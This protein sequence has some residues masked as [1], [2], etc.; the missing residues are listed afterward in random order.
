[1]PRA[2]S[3][4]VTTGA[5]ARGQGGSPRQGEVLTSAPMAENLKT[6]YGYRINAPGFLSL[7][8][9][10]EW[11]EDLK[12]LIGTSGQPFGLLVDIRSQRANPPESQAVI[13]EAMAWV[14]K[15]GLVR[16]AVVLDSA[17]AKLQT[18]RLAKTSGVYAWERYIDASKDL[19]WEKR[20]IDWIAHGIDPDKAVP[21]QKTGT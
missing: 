10:R 12:W 4:E 9:T 16:S 20:A 2:A 14:K 5:G 21:Q 13:T 6:E 7:A 3:V 15:A 11:F 8:E 18:T 19:D 1:M 17:V